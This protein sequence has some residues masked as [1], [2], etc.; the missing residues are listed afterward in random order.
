VGVAMGLPFACSVLEGWVSAPGKRSVGEKPVAGSLIFPCPIRLG[1]RPWPTMQPALAQDP[2]HKMLVGRNPVEGEDLALQPMLSWFENAPDRKRLCRMG[3]ALAECMIERHRRRLH[4]HTR[5]ITLGLDP[6][7]DPTHGAQQ[8]T[9]SNG[10][11]E[12]WCYLPVVGFSSSN[13]EREQYLFTAALRRGDAGAGKGAIG[14]L[15]R[16]LVRVRKAFPKAR[17]RV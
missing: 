15:W 11:Y 3:E 9:F 1:T 16:T 14:I 7:D 12:T 13:D 4:G 17:R 2:V 6:T 8:L 5:R 10:H